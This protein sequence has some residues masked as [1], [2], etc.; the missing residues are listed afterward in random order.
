MFA[1]GRPLRERTGLPVIDPAEASLE[2]AE[3]MA[4]LGL[5]HSRAAYPKYP[6]PHRR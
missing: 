2:T 5:R 3:T 6:P 4:H 1:L